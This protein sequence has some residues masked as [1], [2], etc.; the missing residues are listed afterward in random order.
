MHRGW[1]NLSESTATLAHCKQYS[2]ELNERMGIFAGSSYR[3]MGNHR[4][5][6]LA[7][8]LKKKGVRSN[9]CT[10]YSIILLYHSAVRNL[11]IASTEQV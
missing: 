4:P 10:S 8:V 7:D 5:E 3:Q 9:V 11:R 2:L 6:N 1:G